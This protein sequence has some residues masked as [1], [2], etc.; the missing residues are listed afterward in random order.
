MMRIEPNTV[1]AFS[2]HVLEVF[3]RKGVGKSKL[4]AKFT[5]HLFKGE[6][7]VDGKSSEL[8]IQ[9]TNSLES[10]GKE[11]DVGAEESNGFLFVYD[12][13]N[14]ESFSVVKARLARM[15]EQIRNSPS[16][17][18]E[19]VP[20]PVPHDVDGCVNSG[21][22]A[23]LVGSKYD[24][25][26]R[27][28]IMLVGNKR[29]ISTRKVTTDEGW[30]LAS[31]LGLRFWETSAED[32]TNVESTFFEIIREMRKHEEGASLNASASRGCS[33]CIAL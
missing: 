28:P 25:S 14:V 24:T 27:K 9:E 7:S 26:T 29:D 17:I 33:Q 30:E 8:R 22:P 23:T 3:G 20:Q 31:K 2:S 4:I 10:D 6:L 19:A 5:E 1:P 15:P 11:E 13:S 32:G 16:P 21:T 18:P 12:V